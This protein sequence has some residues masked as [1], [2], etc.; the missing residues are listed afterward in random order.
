M[1]KTSSCGD[2]NGLTLKIRQML[3]ASVKRNL[4]EGILLSGG[5]DT[6]ILAVLASKIVSLRGITVAFQDSVASDVE[7][8]EMVAKELNLEHIIHHFDESELVEA[9][10][11]TIRVMGSFDPMEIRNSSAIYIA[12]KVAKYNGVQS[13]MTGD[14]CDELFAGYSFLFNLDSNRLEMELQRLW[15]IMQFSSVELSKFLGME[16]KLPY[17]DPEFKSLA[18]KIHP[19]L[20]VR[21]EN[22]VKWGKW[23]LRKAFEEM[24]PKEIVWR[25]KTPIEMGTGTFTLPH[26]LNRKISDGEFE[27]KKAKYLKEDKVVIRDKE[28]LL[29]YEIYREVVG[30]PHPVDPKG[31]VCPQ[32]NSNIPEKATYCRVCGAYPV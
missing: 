19:G 30:V 1:E 4:A 25:V 18:M 3:E 29:Y 2:V 12:L 5:L 22:G 9:I 6:S 23:I 8:A 24:L 16:A 11:T 20:K 15:H 13:I 10:Y 21:E 32:C 17:L 14:G 7:Y 26:L 27:E 31:R 28:H